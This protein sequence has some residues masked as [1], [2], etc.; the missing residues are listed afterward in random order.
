MTPRYGSVNH[1]PDYNDRQRYVCLQLMHRGQRLADQPYAARYPGLLTDGIDDS[2]MYIY[3]GIAADCLRGAEYLLSHP[4]IDRSRVA[5]QGDDLAL[6][7]AS[8]RPGFAFVEVSGLMFF[9][10]PERRLATDAYPVEEVNDFCRA[11]PDRS[12]AVDE[13][14][15][16]FDPVHHTDGL[17]SDVILSV[18]DD[19]DWHAP[20]VRSLGDRCDI[21]QITHRGRVDQDEID[22]RIAERLG[23]D[24]MSKFVTC[25]SPT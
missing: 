23:S 8:R 13:T 18:G 22:R 6:L 2:E 3:R 9:R 17:S 11:Y 15:R 19:P 4:D 16:L 5:V 14:L 24:P 20:L 21:Y 10:L 25:V 1:I 7:S 12:N